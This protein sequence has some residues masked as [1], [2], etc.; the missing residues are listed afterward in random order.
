MLHAPL[1]P[2]NVGNGFNTDRM[3]QHGRVNLVALIGVSTVLLLGAALGSAFLKES[4]STTASKFM[5]ALA[6]GDAETLTD[7]TYRGDFTREQILDQWKFSTQVAGKHYM[8]RWQILDEKQA[9]E[10]Q[11]T[12]QM[13]IWRNYGP[14]SYEERYGL[15]LRK[16]EGKWKVDVSGIAR[17]MYPG[18]PRLDGTIK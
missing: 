6:R 18:L 16:E 2:N 10:D 12:V 5:D 11:G 8:F 3:R 1:E 9:D 17:N 7:L 15:E 13:F 14:G 4:L